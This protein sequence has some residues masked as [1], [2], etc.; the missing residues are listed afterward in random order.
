ML[1]RLILTLL[2]Y[3]G[4]VFSDEKIPNRILFLMQ[5]GH[6]DQAIN[7]Y[8]E[9]IKQQQHDLDLLRNMGM[10]LLDQGYNS[11]DPEVQLLT[12]FGAGISSNEGTLYILLEGL[13]NKNPILQIIAMNFIA[14]YQN[15]EADLA[16][17]RALSS[18]HLLIRLEGA[19]HLARKKAPTAVPQAEALMSKVN[20][21]V[22]PL[23]PQLYAI[24]GN[25]EAI[26]ILRKLMAHPNEDV[27]IATILSA[28]E[29]GRDDL[30][31][32]IRILAT[33]HALAQQEACAAALGMMKDESS[34]TKL[35][36]IASSGSLTTRIAAW[37]ALY[38]LGRKERRLDIEAAAKQ[39]DLFAITVL[40]DIEGSEAT[41]FTL[42]QS[43]NL[44][45]KIN[46]T[47]ALLK[48]KDPRCLKSLCDVLIRDMRDLAFQKVSSPGGALTS[49]KVIPSA[50]Q[51]LEENTA[52]QELSLT[53]REDALLKALELPEEDFLKLANTLFDV[54]QN[55]LIPTLVEAL[56]NLRSQGSIT[57][58]KRHQ[59]KAGAPLIR[60]YCNLALYRL[61][62]EG[63]Y[64]ANLKAWIEKEQRGELINFRPFLAWGVRDKESEVA[65]TYQLT[66]QETSK[67]LIESFEALI[68][69]Q[70]DLGID[71]LLQ[72]IQEGN[73]KNKYALAGLLIHAAQ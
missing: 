19:F 9:H 32:S 45:V 67:L 10:T 69:N 43:Q 65:S 35:E 53:L 17:N 39:N 49:Y 50:Q 12:L 55:D 73:T 46:A 30:L 70:D 14:T 3:V 21:D 23:F 41:L 27:R 44:Q 36:A 20:T 1:F 47:L 40:G 34:V 57:L 66:P 64:A 71:I 33:H 6:T 38:R 2:L 28:A 29:Y 42:T 25:A 5:A 11:S 16:I 48:R 56:E 61:K 15:D 4:T 7:L 13:K 72:A 59:Q 8:R 62:E 68:Q 31:P 52:G 26:R 18:N 24:V 51:N 63:P 58:L 60:N 37:Q 22:W 54:R